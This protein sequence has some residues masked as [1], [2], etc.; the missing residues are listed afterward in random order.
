M[1]GSGLMDK[2]KS[3]V[4]PLPDQ[5]STASSIIDDVARLINGN[6]KIV[7]DV[8][9]HHGRYTSEFL[10]RI[11]VEKVICFEPFPDSFLTLNQNLVSSVCSH[12]QLALSDYTGSADFYINCFDETNSLLRSVITNSEIDRLTAH[13]RTITVNVD[14]VENF[15]RKNSISEIDL[16]KIDT[17]GNSFKVL[18]GALELLMKR[19]IKLIQCEVEFLEIYEGEQ[20]FH[21]IASFLEAYGYSLYSLYNIHYDVNGRVSWAD[22]LFFH[23]V[24]S[25]KAKN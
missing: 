20:L 14:T 6:A 22:A 5:A 23:Y 4:R 2:I 3:L 24:T 1:I 12:Q 11:K 16:L 25:N 21:K 10:K 9:A 8:G 18:N 7:F 13:V 17:Q 19:A 15:C